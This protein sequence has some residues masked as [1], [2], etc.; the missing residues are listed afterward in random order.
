[1]LWVLVLLLLLLFPL[2]RKEDMNDCFTG[3]RPTVFV[4]LVL[5]GATGGGEGREFCRTKKRV[6]SRSF[7]FSF[8]SSTE[9]DLGLGDASIKGYYYYYER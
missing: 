8:S 7:S 5:F 6:S 1:M 9:T 3:G 2:L 4:L